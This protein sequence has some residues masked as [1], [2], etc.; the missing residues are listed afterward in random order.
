[1]EAKKLK[2]KKNLDLVL[3][4]P[5]SFYRFALNIGDDLQSLI[6]SSQLLTSNH[7]LPCIEILFSE[8]S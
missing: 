1:M 3:L 5:R 6:T 7:F 2:T 4:K 8:E